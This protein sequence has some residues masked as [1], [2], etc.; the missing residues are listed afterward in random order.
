[1]ET[2]AVLNKHDILACCRSILNLFNSL[3][4]AQLYSDF[5]TYQCLQNPCSGKTFILIQ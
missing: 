3:K 1:M 2:Y 5:G 4:T